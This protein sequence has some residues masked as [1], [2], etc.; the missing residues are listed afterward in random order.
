MPDTISI[1]ILIAFHHSSQTIEKTV[2]NI[3]QVNVTED[4][5]VTLVLVENGKEQ[6]YES[7]FDNKLYLG[8]VNLEYHY[9]SEKGKS[10][11]LNFAIKEFKDDEFIIFTDDDIT[12]NKDWVVKY[13]DSIRKNPINSFFGGG[14]QCNYEIEPSSDIKH[15][16]P[17][18]ALGVADDYYSEIK[19]KLFLGCNWGCYSS[20]IKEAGYF[21][22][23]LGPGTNKTGQESDMQLR[24]RNMDLKQIYIPDNL[25]AH[26]VPSN[27]SDWDFIVN[28]L[29]RIIQEKKVLKPNRW[30][31][32]KTEV[33]LGIK[34]ILQSPK[35]ISALN[36]TMKYISI[37]ICKAV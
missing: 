3:L 14:M 15:L 9:I 34:L 35:N 10:R 26:Y 16:L 22:E 8:P 27:R 18:S 17:K 11:A 30:K 5:E 13:V 33:A 2:N 20:Y 4:F 32:L 21:N 1:K 19:S 28:R 12:V 24:L 37:R 36:F 7:K 25:V 23:E 6:K 31:R 29:N